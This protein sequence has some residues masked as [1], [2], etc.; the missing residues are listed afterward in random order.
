MKKDPP[1]KDLLQVGE[2]NQA[3]YTVPSVCCDKEIY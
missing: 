1:K 3:I 2:R